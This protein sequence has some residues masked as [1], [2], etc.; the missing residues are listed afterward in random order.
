MAYVDGFVVP[1]PKKNLDLY[2]KISRKAGKIWMDCG[3][4][5]YCECAGDD[6]KVRVGPGFPSGLKTGKG[7]TVFFSW[8]RF[9]SRAHR[10]RVNAKAMADPRMAKL[11]QS[12]EGGEAFECG[13]M[14]Y[15]G[16][17][18]VVSF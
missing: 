13:R 18:P 3:A 8:I 6:L 4:V 12:M 7:E 2:R 9:K 5:E 1:V 14:L 11:M 17:K 15:G 16:F 10:D